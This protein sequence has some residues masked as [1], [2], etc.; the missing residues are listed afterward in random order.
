MSDVTSGSSKFLPVFTWGGVV[1][2]LIGLFL[3][4]RG[5]PNTG[6]LVAVAGV[7]SW[8]FAKRRARRK[9]E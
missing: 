8:L 9:T 5:Q 3:L 2:V 1:L 4:V 6:L 7:V